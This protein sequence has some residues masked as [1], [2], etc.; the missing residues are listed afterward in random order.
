[1]CEAFNCAPDRSENGNFSLGAET[2]T[3]YRKAAQT[4]IL[5]I[6]FENGSFSRSAPQFLSGNYSPAISGDFRYPDVVW[7]L[8]RKVII[9]PYHI[10]TERVHCLGHHLPQVSIKKEGHA[11]DDSNANAAISS[12]LGTSKSSW[13]SSRDSPASYRSLRTQVGIPVLSTT[14]APKEIRGSINIGTSLPRGYHCSAKS[15]SY[16][17]WSKRR[18]IRS[19]QASCP[20]SSATINFDVSSSSSSK[21]LRI[22]APSVFSLNWAKGY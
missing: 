4:V 1:L 16:S 9:M 21:S 17:N 7:G 12:L 5:D 3:V 15:L 14:G 8:L 22:C 20:A 11:D 10:N 13:I 18:F 19:V 2:L 6:S